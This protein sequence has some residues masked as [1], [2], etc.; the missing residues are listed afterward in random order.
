MH[1]AYLLLQNLVSVAGV[2]PATS[3]FGGMRSVQ[4]SYTDIET[5]GLIFFP[6]SAA[7]FASAIFTA[8]GGST[9]AILRKFAISAFTLLTPSL[10]IMYVSLQTWGGWWD[11]NPR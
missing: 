2:E 1:V 7:R 11:S 8:P 6:S 3:S 10:S 4:L 9:F 5:Y